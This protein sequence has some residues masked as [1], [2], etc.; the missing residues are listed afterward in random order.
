MFVGFSAKDLMETHCEK[1]SNGNFVPYG[2][3]AGLPNWFGKP[4]Y[5]WM[6]KTDKIHTCNFS[7]NEKERYTDIY[8]L[9]QK[10]YCCDNE[11]ERDKNTLLVEQ[12]T[13]QMVFSLIES[14]LSY[15][16]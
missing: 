7:N 6:V 12:S 9:A 11:A 2:T 16:F 8:Q 14:F 15:L 4:F 3:I 1:D 13:G 5:D 10:F